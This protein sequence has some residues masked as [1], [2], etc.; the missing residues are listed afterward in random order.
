V[1][2]TVTVPA[3]VPQIKVDV[4]LKAT[5]TDGKALLW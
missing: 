1:K 4:V 3:G 2:Q 5:G